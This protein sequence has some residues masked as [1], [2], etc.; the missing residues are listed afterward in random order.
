MDPKEFRKLCER[1]KLDEEAN[2]SLNID[3]ADCDEGM[4]SM[5]LS[6]VGEDFG[7]KTSK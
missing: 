6:L 4:N 7:V 5:Q 2:P 3:S 1:L